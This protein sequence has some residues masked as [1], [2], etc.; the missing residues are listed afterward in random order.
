MNERISTGI[1]SLDKTIEGGYKKRSINLIEGGPGTGKSIFSMQY[2]LNGISKGENGV[3]ITFEEEKENL[4]DNLSEF[5]WNLDKLIKEE[6]LVILSMSPE[7]IKETVEKKS[8]DL[9]FEILKKIKAH[10]IVIDS[11]TA[12]SLL[13][14]SG[15]KRIEALHKLFSALRGFDCTSLLISEREVTIDS[16]SLTK[17]DIEFEVDSIIALYNV[18]KNNTRERALE[19]KKIRGT[20]NLQK[21][22]PMKITDK[23][24][25]IFPNQAFF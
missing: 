25:D 11:V 14:E 10:R 8:F 4:I 16:D 15:I 5:N 6:K 1:T 13:F 19:V 2:L 20:K 3:Y 18:R 17:D 21:I 22:F 24:I 9:K 7:E 12:Y 23:C